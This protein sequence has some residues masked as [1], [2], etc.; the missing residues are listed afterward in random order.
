MNMLLFFKQSNNLLILL[1]DSFHYKVSKW[2]YG[3][4][5]G[6]QPSV[7]ERWNQP[8]VSVNSEQLLSNCATAPVPREGIGE[9]GAVNDSHRI[10]LKIV[11]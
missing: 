9:G 7:E 3:I 10:W 5:N 4:P 6:E 11:S 2:Y 1:S 8:E